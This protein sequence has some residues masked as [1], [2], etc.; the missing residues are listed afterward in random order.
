MKSSS[1]Y[2]YERLPQKRSRRE[3]AIEP[4]MSASEAR[5]R[6][7][8]D[9]SGR[10]A[11]IFK[12]NYAQAQRELQYLQSECDNIVDILHKLEKIDKQA[13]QLVSLGDWTGGLT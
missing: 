2:S 4:T 13:I 3:A 12:D 5:A 1:H 7:R 8:V 11:I 6:L 10:S 9:E